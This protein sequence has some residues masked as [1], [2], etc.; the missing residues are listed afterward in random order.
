MDEFYARE[1]E[2]QLNIIGTHCKRREGR[3]G[4][5]VPPQRVPPQ[6]P[7]QTR[8]RP[9]PAVRRRASAPPPPRF[10]SGRSG[11]H[12][13][14]GAQASRAEVWGEMRDS[15]SSGLRRQ[16]FL[17]SSRSSERI[18]AARKLA[19]RPPAR[20]RRRCRVRASLPGPRPQGRP[21]P[22]RARSVLAQRPSGRG[23]GPRR[24]ALP[25]GSR[26]TQLGRMDAK[27][28]R[29]GSSGSI[30]GGGALGP[31][32]L[33]EPFIRSLPRPTPGAKRQVP[34]I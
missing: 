15:N 19:S 16:L 21:G 33:A 1:L 11:F 24:A 5:G 3:L 14:P 34:R 17:K 31:Q 18:P 30:P 32:S 28:G 2:R 4:G 27:K 8:P 6:D 12:P 25:S 22:Q 29:A 26:A 9:F 13:H 10:P 23:L 7:A 20:P